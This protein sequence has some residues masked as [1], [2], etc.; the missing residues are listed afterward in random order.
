MRLTI[1]SKANQRFIKDLSQ[2][3][4]MTDKECLDYLLTSMRLN[5]LPSNNFPQSLPTYD[6]SILEAYQPQSNYEQSAIE[7]FTADPVIEKFAA[8]IEDF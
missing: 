1:S 4:A 3:Y 7:E 5:G 2:R 6:D 8:L